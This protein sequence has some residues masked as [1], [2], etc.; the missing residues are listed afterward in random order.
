[1]S[2]EHALESDGE[3]PARGRGC[4]SVCRNGEVMPAEVGTYFQPRSHVCG[5]SRRPGLLWPGGPRQ[6]LEARKGTDGSV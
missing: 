3:H 6:L 1:M 5:C 2:V 4:A